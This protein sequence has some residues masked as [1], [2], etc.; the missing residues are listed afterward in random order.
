VRLAAAA[1][2]GVALGVVVTAFI[3]T[4]IG[5][6]GVYIAGVPYAGLLSAAIFMLCIAQV[7]PAPV[8]IPA[9]IWMYYSSD[10]SWA[11]VPPVISVVAIG[12]DNFIRPVLIRRGADLPILLILAGVIGGLIAFG[13]IG[14]FIGPTV[15]AVGYTLLD[16]WIKEGD[17]GVA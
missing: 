3:Q 9:I 13:L 10:T 6:A 16:A 14:I 15:L 12:I 17:E 7:G 2:R 5:A 11:T 8:L 1:I 4:A